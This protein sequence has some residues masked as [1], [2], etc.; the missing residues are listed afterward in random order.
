MTS[1]S[2]R[3]RASGPSDAAGGAGPAARGGKAGPAARSGK[4]SPGPRAGGGS[5]RGGAAAPG[6]R[7]GGTRRWRLV[8]ANPDAVPPSVRRF[9]Q[10]ARQRRLRAALPWALI[11]AV[12]ALAALLTWIVV[13]TGVFGVREVRVVG[14]ELVTPDQVRQAADVPAGTPLAR[15]DLA[16]VRSRV[17]ELA[18]VGRV[19]VS[20]QWPDTVLVEVV[21]RTPA[22]VVPQ[23]ER[24]AVVDSVGV[25]FQT[26]PSRPEQLPLIRVATP[27]P[28]D[29]ATRSALQVLAALTPE[30]R[31]R[32][33]EVLVEGPA[34]IKVLLQ[35]GRTVIWG[36]PTDG[37]TKARVAT[38]LLARKGDVIDVRAPD[39]VTIR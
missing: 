1:G 8:R 37:G 36:D 15:V 9:T 20:R 19:T 24:F 2:T 17:A 21:E 13:G 5:A 29:G 23:G 10:R 39:V 32:L 31:E 11:G 18:P 34:R 35:G 38:A 27:G 22:A 30:L 6:A 16:A 3:G 26:L 14:G 12:L 7:A 4:A 28:E 33:V 25:V